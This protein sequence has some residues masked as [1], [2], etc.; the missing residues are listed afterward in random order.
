M[1]LVAVFRKYGSDT[2]GARSVIINYMPV[3]SIRHGLL[4]PL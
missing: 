4:L 3:R 1:M 2:S